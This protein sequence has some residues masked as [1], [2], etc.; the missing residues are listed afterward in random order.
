[1]SFSSRILYSSHRTIFGLHHQTEHCAQNKEKPIFYTSTCSVGLFWTLQIR[2]HRLRLHR[3]RTGVVNRLQIVLQ[4]LQLR[5]GSE[6]RRMVDNTCPSSS[7]K[8]PME[9]LMVL[10]FLYFLPLC[11]FFP[12]RGYLIFLNFP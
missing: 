12:L 3:V 10:Y 4:A 2:S 8:D 11:S 1:M 7:E 6:G 9:A 5:G